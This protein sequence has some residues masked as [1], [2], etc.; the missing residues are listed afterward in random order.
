M[1]F[2]VFTPV[3]I[4]VWFALVK[5]KNPVFTP[6]PSNSPNQLS[7]REEGWK[8]EEIFFYK[9]ANQTE[10]FTGVKTENDIY[11]KGEKHY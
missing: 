5:K 10:I 2:S 1:S 9:D 7:W 11:Y 8:P 4:S 3:K 6:P